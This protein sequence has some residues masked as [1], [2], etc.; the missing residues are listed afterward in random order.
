MYEVE[1]KIE[2]NY[3]KCRDI[4][5]RLLSDGFVDMGVLAQFDYYTE[6]RLSDYGEP[7]AF[8]TERYRSEGGRFFHTKKYWE[9]VKGRKPI[10]KEEEREITAKD[11]ESIIATHPTALKISKDRHRFEG[12]FRGREVH[13]SIDSVKFGHSDM[14]RHFLEPEILVKDR[15]EV[16][17]TKDFLYQFVADLLGC[18]VSEIREAPGMFAMAY[19]KI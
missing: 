8:D 19:Y 13:V 17:S 16:L 7:K 4:F 1:I 18:E 5:A 2:I 9:I 14:L 11:F 6:A 12:S 15:G 3:W 10:R